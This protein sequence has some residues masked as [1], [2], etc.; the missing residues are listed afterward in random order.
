MDNNNSTMLDCVNPDNVPETEVPE[1]DVV[2]TSE[3]APE[4]NEKKKKGA[5]K[6]MARRKA[7][8][9]ARDFSNVQ[10]QPTDGDVAVADKKMK[11]EKAPNV[12]T[13][14]GYRVFAA[15]IAALAVGLIFL[16]FSYVITSKLEQMS[17]FEAIKA[18][19]ASDSKWFN[20][21]PALA[22]T[23][24]IY[25]VFA[26]ISLY[27]LLLCSVIAFVLG[28]ITIFCKNKAPAMLRVTTFFLAIGYALYTICVFLTNYVIR[29]TFLLDFVCIG[30]T[31]FTALLFFILACLK[32]GKKAVANAVYWL[33]SLVVSAA[34]ILTIAK[35]QDA[36]KAGLNILPVNDA[37]K[38][39]II[40][41]VLGLSIVNV[42]I[43][44]IRVATVK[45]LIFDLVRYSVMF[46]LS[47]FALL[48]ALKDTSTDFFVDICAIVA[49]AAAFVQILIVVIILIVKGKDKRAARQAKKQAKKQDAD[50]GADYAIDAE[51]AQDATN[52][53]AATQETFTVG[54]YA[55]AIPYDGGPV[56]GVETA[57]EIPEETQELPPIPAPTVE[58]ADYDY[59]NTRSFDPFIATLTA[60]ERNHF[61]DLYILKCRGAMPEIPDYNVGSNNKE[62]F[63]KIFIYLG[64]YRNKIPDSLLAKMYEFTSK[65][66]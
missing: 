62:F 40:Y 20:V 9:G 37:V 14:V 44:S 57:E 11:K 22:D 28:F 6:K 32:I 24:A 21:I 41:A 47:A 65:V 30:A 39:I 2:A 45:G 58:T 34:F 7:K 19:L 15:I 46:V 29:G 16:P 36:F 49:T 10:D 66:N 4:T 53:D 25:G 55:Q 59:Y 52:A 33:L 5:H 43:A 61:T 13:N 54:D 38:E 31:A 18:L 42:I 27:V 35:D 17:F 51:D 1:T 64:Q 23:S 56:S 63:R 50:Q 60:E 26:T 3:D 12:K 48:F 8:H